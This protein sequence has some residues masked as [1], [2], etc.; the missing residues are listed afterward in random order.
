MGFPTPFATW[1]RGTLLDEAQDILCSPST[2]QRDVL[3]SRVVGRK[4]GEHRRG[5]RDHGAWIWRW[6]TLE[7]W[8]RQFIDGPTLSPT[9]PI[10]EA[11]ALTH[12]P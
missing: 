8:F 6:V 7:L 2:R 10:W 12:R 5:E 1:S 9:Y 3:D 11:R 4:L